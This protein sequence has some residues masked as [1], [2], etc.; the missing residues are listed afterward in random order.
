M[1]LFGKIS[2]F[3]YVK[4]SIKSSRFLF[5]AQ[6]LKTTDNSAHHSPCFGINL[7]E[8]SAFICGHQLYYNFIRPHQA[9][10]NY[11]PAHFA[12]IYLN[13]GEKKWENLLMQSLK[14]QKIC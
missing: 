14:N 13:L 8:D 1:L 12:N 4:I 3:F 7:K 11:T 10:N 6:P 9:L 2:D 5:N